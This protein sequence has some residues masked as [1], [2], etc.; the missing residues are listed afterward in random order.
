M[1][2][3]W[4][5]Q[6][7]IVAY[8]AWSV[9]YAYTGLN[10]SDDSSPIY[11]WLD[12]KNSMHSAI[13]LALFV[14]ILLDPAIFLMC[15]N[16]SR[17]LPRRLRVE[18]KE[19]VKKASTV[20]S[21]EDVD[22]THDITHDIEEGAVTSCDEVVF[23]DVDMEEPKED[24]VMLSMPKD[25]EASNNASPQVTTNR[26]EDIEDLASFPSIIY[27]DGDASTFNSS[28]QE[29]QVSSRASSLIDAYIE[30]KKPYE[31]LAS[32]A[33]YDE[34]EDTDYSF[35]KEGVDISF[36]REVSKGG[37]DFDN[38]SFPDLLSPVKEA[39]T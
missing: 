3:F 39:D 34:G 38:V 28:I 26:N 22:I 16:V 35:D 1:K 12:W 14:L 2:Q 7:I 33:G 10:M 25:E 23:G 17:M 27:D 31:D 18:N 29:T 15:R 13:L 30:T 37:H 8:L 4:L 5:F 32:F 6:F 9:V 21:A 20:Q 11:A 36:E 19:V 24:N